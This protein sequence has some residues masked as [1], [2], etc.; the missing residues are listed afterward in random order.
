MRLEPKE[1]DDFIFVNESLVT[2][3]NNTIKK[4]R[5]IELINFGNMFDLH[6]KIWILSCYANPR[7]VSL[8]PNTQKNNE[9]S[10]CRDYYY[11]KS[12]ERIYKKNPIYLQTLIK[13]KKEKDEIVN[14]RSHLKYYKYKK[15]K[16]KRTSNEYYKWII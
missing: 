1:K 12:L 9:E 3:N 4:S 8:P 15:G 10:N 6:Y 16:I 13:E 11:I 14:S 7:L 5:K 2:I